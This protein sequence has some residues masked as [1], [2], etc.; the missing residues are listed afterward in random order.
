MK[1]KLKCRLIW[2]SWKQQSTGDSLDPQISI[3]LPPFFEY[4]LIFFFPDIVEENRNK[5]LC[6]N[7]GNLILEKP[8]KNPQPLSSFMVLHYSRNYGTSV[9]FSLL[10]FHAFHSYLNRMTS[11]KRDFENLHTASKLLEV[12]L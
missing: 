9:P 3:P 6:S 2:T 8:W 5:E 4:D 7:S 1:W 11:L 12:N 10:S